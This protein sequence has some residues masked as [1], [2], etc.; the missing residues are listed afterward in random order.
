[1]K[2]TELI[3]S[4]NYHILGRGKLLMSGEVETNDKRS[5][6]F[7]FCTNIDMVPEL[8]LIVY[9]IREDGELVSDSLIIEL[10]PKLNNFVSIIEF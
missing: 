8:S 9:Y 3:A 2:S 7:K 5:S 1:V 10:E 6:N 4:Y